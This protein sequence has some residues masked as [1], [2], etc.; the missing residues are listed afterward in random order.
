MGSGIATTMI[1][2]NYP[3]LLKEVS[4]EL[5]NVGIDRIKGRNMLTTNYI[6]STNCICF[7]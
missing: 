4:E 5:L 6:L 2:S 7:V 3:V 1:L